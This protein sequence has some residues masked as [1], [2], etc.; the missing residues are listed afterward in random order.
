MG[1]VRVGALIEGC[2]TARERAATDYSVAS[3]FAKATGRPRPYEP[4][5][6][7]TSRSL[8]KLRTSSQPGASTLAV[9]ELSDDG[10]R[11]EEDMCSFESDD[12]GVVNYGHVRCCGCGATYKRADGHDCAD[13][14]T[15][16]D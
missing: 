8:S 9:F 2:F 4:N 7:R 5:L 10:D 6:W 15:R 16:E 14:S 11:R 3:Y 1:A 12:A 13:D